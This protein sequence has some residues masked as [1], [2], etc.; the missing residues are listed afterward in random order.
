[1]NSNS[2]QYDPPLK[3]LPECAKD[4]NLKWITGG[5][6]YLFDFM[7]DGAPKADFD[8]E[9]PGSRGT[10]RTRYYGSLEGV[11]SEAKELAIKA[12]SLSGKSMHRWLTDVIIS[13]AK[14]QIL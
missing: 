3:C 14:S 10:H 12:Q 5:V 8:F 13:E 1:M 7:L 9:I 11:T 2:Y 4:V 6:F